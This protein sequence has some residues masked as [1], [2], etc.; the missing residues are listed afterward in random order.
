[1]KLKFKNEIKHEGKTNTQGMKLMRQTKTYHM[2]EVTFMKFTTQIKLQM[3][4]N[5]FY[6]INEVDKTD[7][8]KKTYG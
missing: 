8:K 6:N 7:D 5:E 4:E 3:D 2:D 1:M